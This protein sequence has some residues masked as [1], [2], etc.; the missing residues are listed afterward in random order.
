MKF[1]ILTAVVLFLTTAANAEV[2]FEA[3]VNVEVTAEN[4]AAA[5][6]NAMK[7]ANREAFLKVAERLTTPENV[8]QLNQLS[9][10]QLL[11]FIREVSVVA[12]KSGTDSYRADLNILINGALLKQYMQENGM[13]AVVG[14]PGKVMVVPAFSDT[15]FAGS[16]LWEDGNV[17]RSAWLDQGLIKSGMLDI[18][19]IDNTTANLAALDAVKALNM[20][21]DTYEKISYLNNVKDIF[22]V[23]AVRAGRNNLVLVIRG[24]PQMSEKR[25]VVSDENG[26]I[27]A[28]AIA[29]A[30]RYITMLEEGKN[31]VE[32]QQTNKISAVYYYFKLKEWLQTEKKLKNVPQIQSVQ[33]GGLG[34][35]KVQFEVEYSGSLDKLNISLEQ[36]GLK[37]VEDQGRYI[38]K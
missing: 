36:A 3:G 30:V 33:T 7:K 21:Q 6:D 23:H 29:E 13:L 32:S 4:A 1:A 19:V 16:V 31:L 5:K 2:S 15:E 34:G 11:H 27:F 37:L 10:E 8:V 14:T 18:S 26:E 17:W 9:D 25:F 12:E 20:N 22:V 28:K 35:G 24:Y 38:L